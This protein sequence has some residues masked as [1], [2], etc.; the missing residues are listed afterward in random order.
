[1]MCFFPFTLSNDCTPLVKMASH[2]V[3]SAAARSDIDGSL[4]RRAYG[5][6]RDEGALD[7]DLLS[8]HPVPK[9]ERRSDAWSWNARHKL[10]AA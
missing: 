1:M 9:D 4:D 6:W 8:L 10:L 7:N 5:N 2:R 3:A